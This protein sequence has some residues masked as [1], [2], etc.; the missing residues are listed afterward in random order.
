MLKLLLYLHKQTLIYIIWY[1]LWRYCI[2]FEIFQVRVSTSY[3]KPTSAH[4]SHSRRCISGWVLGI[5]RDAHEIYNKPFVTQHPSV[6]WQHNLMYVTTQTHRH[7][8]TNTHTHTWATPLCKLFG[9]ASYNVYP[10]K[11]H[12]LDKRSRVHVTRWCRRHYFIAVFA[13]ACINMSCKGFILMWIGTWARFLFV[14]LFI[15][16]PEQISRSISEFVEAGKFIV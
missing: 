12:I 1:S 6:T 5:R 7:T 9:C 14:R 11:Y 4:R 13:N 10:V 8:K 2:F 15:V 3:T 16:T